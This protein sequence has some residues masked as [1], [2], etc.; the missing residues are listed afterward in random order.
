MHKGRLT[1]LHSRQHVSASKNYRPLKEKAERLIR[2]ERSHTAS[3]KGPG[4]VQGEKMV[5]PSSNRTS[6]TPCPFGAQQPANALSRY[7][8]AVSLGDRNLVE[9]ADKPCKALGKMSLV[10]NDAKCHNGESVYK[11]TSL[12]AKEQGLYA[13]SRSFPGG[14]CGPGSPAPPRHLFQ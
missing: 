1:F 2:R 6:H 4:E 11:H 8:E 5:F 3:A 14:L 10:G 9:S 13:A 12:F 7:H